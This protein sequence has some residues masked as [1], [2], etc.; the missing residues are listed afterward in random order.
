MKRHLVATVEK[1]PISSRMRDF[2]CPCLHFLTL[3][4]DIDI[5]L[6]N[7]FQPP[8]N[9]FRIQSKA[10]GRVTLD[11]IGF[12]VAKESRQGR[13][14]GD[15]HRMNYCALPDIM[16]TRRSPRNFF[17]G[18]LRPPP[19]PRRKFRLIMAAAV[20]AVKKFTRSLG[21]STI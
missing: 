17:F 18:R 3:P 11:W 10:T 5:N 9:V 13:K 12:R 16:T 7:Q 8:W 20:R 14:D 1:L 21:V 6:D 15:T 19:P 2:P 4:L